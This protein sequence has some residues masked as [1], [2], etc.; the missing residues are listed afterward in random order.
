LPAGQHLVIVSIA[1]PEARIRRLGT[2]PVR[3][4]GRYVLYWMIAARRTRYSFALQ[5]A[6][7]IATR[8]GVPLLVFEPLGLRYRWASARFHRFV[9]DGMCDQA[10]AFSRA[11]ISY[12]PRL[13]TEPNGDRGLLRALSQDAALVVTDDFPCGFYPSLITAAVAQLDCA[14]HVVDGNG[15]LPM[16]ECGRAFSTAHAF[17]R[18]LQRQLV[19]HGLPALPVERP[20]DR[21]NP[22]KA[23]ISSETLAR[24]PATSMAMLAGE[25]TTAFAR[26]PI[27]HS[28]GPT[29]RRGGQESAG[30]ALD[31]FLRQR[32]GRYGDD[33]NH[34]DANGA[35]GLSP[36]LHF[37][38]LA[39]HAAIARVVPADWQPA[40][41][42]KG[43]R[44]GFWGLAEPVEAW[45]DQLITWRELGYGAAC[46]A[47]D[48][49]AYTSLPAWARRT[50][51]AHAEDERPVLYTPDQLE[52]AETHDALWN[53]AQTELVL[54]GRIHNYLRM[55]WA[56]KILEWTPQPA[57]AMATMVALNDKYALDG[58][59]PNS[60]SG[61]GWALGR[62]DRA[63][64]PERP[65]FG[66]VRYMTSLSAARKLRLRLYLRRMESR[67]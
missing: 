67:R 42:A 41:G 3:P 9:M 10:A 64:G 32:L 65:I 8:L 25:D 1:I 45:L 11:G 47:P 29:D 34:P 12:Y 60:Y 18:H 33:R 49:D 61:I 43:S 23:A 59:D 46:H 58:R 24:W 28:V 36:W 4:D 54:D 50:L 22:S 56:K 14:L 51:E 16:R 37:G 15:L 53:A 20:L 30:A 27:D 44:G 52:R 66:K 40:T 13:E 55:L 62:F 17:R 7:E 6:V 39:V 31:E 48:F 38:Q 26:L 35:S 63:W 5:H 19:E 57:A 21:A 2:A